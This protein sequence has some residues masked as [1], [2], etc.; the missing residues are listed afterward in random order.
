MKA[1]AVELNEF[2]DALERNAER[3][4]VELTAAGIE[5]LA[6]YYQLLLE[7]NLRAHLVAPCTPDEFATRHVLESLL[8]LPHLSRDARI[9]D[10]GSGAGLPI[11]PV[12]IVRPDVRATLI[13]SS[14]RKSVFLRE[15]LRITELPKQAIVIGERFE[16]ISAPT[17]DCVSCRALDGFTK[18]F[19]TLVRW[20]P[21]GSALLLFGGEAL[22]KTIGQ[23]GL[24]YKLIHIPDSDRRFLFVIKSEP[25]AVLTLSNNFNG[26]EL[27]TGDHKFSRR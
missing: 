13:E 23:A 10:V 18:L 15:A 24:D 7:W 14:K 11:I 19:S 17:A 20:A 2:R 12:L 4:E 6:A 27:L 25:P 21:A 16:N 26:D 22:R 3:Y 8:L 5:R 1:V 9:A